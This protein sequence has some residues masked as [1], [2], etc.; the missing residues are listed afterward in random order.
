MS[1]VF[2][3]DLAGEGHGSGEEDLVDGGAKPVLSVLGQN[4]VDGALGIT[5]ADLAEQG[6]NREHQR[7]SQP[8]G[9]VELAGQGVNI[10][11]GDWSRWILE[12]IEV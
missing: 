5:A 10:F 11:L 3:D 1:G 7:S 9:I 6:S 4:G 8:C 12:K 2:E